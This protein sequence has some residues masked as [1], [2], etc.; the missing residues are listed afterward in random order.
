MPD[1]VTHIPCDPPPPT[2]A[3]V[4]TLIDFPDA[5]FAFGL[6]Q[7]EDG[8]DP[9]QQPLKPW[10]TPSGA[11]DDTLL[12]ES[13][14]ESGNLNEAK[15]VGGTQSYDLRLQ[16]GAPRLCCDFVPVVRCSFAAVRRGLCVW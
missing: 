7:A 9:I 15:R 13:R 5:A 8:D 3:A 1:V 16:V 14:F 2:R 10:Y 11:G 12:F 6:L 4:R